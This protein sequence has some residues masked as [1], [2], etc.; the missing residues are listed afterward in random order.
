[1][2]YIIENSAIRVEISDLGA[3]LM[4]IVGKKTGF[5]YLW[6]G[7]AEYWSSRASVLFPICGRL[8]E[9]KYTYRG[10]TYEMVLHG[11]A[12]KQVFTV[13]EQKAD[14]IT[15]ELRPNEASREA[16]PFDFI[17]RVIYTLDGASV[18]TTLAVENPGKENLPFS[19][20]GHPGFNIPFV[21]GESFE[22]Y[23]MEFKCAQP[24]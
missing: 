4:S 14:A 11:F 18:R 19:V 12:R 13:V 3:E 20:G 22:D 23:Y 17:F 1:M 15:F 2:N 7:D 8:T 21:E 10:K 16:Y 9:G 5:E 6:Q 24:T